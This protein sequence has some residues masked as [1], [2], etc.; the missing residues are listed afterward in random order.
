[1]P[2]PRDEAKMPSIPDG[3]LSESMPEWLRRPPAW[4]TLKDDDVVQ[5]E[6]V[7]AEHLP[8]PDTTV[9][10]PRSLLTD[11]DLP[12]WLR[13]MGRGRRS[14]R[15]LPGD[16]DAVESGVRRDDQEQEVNGVERPASPVTAQTAP[17]GA[18]SRFVP[19][20]PAVIAPARASETT[21]RAAPTVSG[22]RPAP[23]PWWQGASMVLLLSVLLLAALV[24]IAYLTLY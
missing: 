24:A 9:I 23:S 10:D 19:R 15:D 4:R 17:A 8:E 16:D 21:K 6:P 5:T 7:V 22:H 14:R 18:T 1:M 11:D 20:Y 13:N 2:D 12:L 3:G